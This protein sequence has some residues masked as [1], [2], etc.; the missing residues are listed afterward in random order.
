MRQYL[1]DALSRGIKIMAL[2]TAEKLMAIKLD[3]SLLLN[4]PAG[5]TVPK[6][7][8]SKVKA[9]IVHLGVGG[10]HRSHQALYMDELI[11][12]F[13]QTEWGIC[14]VGIMPG[15]K[16]MNRALTSQDFLYTL[17]EREGTRDTAKIIGSLK[18]HIFGVENPEA[19]FEAIASAETKI[20]SLTATEGGYCF[21]QA[22]GEFDTKHPGIINDL[23]NPMEPKTIF[24]YIAQGLSRRM[25]NGA[26]PVTILS[27]DNMQGN[28]KIAKKMVLA[29][30][31]LS[32]PT[33]AS[34]IEKN[35]TFPNTMVDRITPVTTE[36]ERELV[37]SFGIDDQFPVV[38]E[39][40]RQWVI[41]DNFAAGRP[42]LEK[43]G[44]Q[45]SA[46]VAPYEKMKIRLLNATHSAMGYLG[47]LCGHKFIHEI[48]QDKD[49][50]PYL[51]ERPQ[52]ICLLSGN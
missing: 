35:V 5:V 14:G 44:V 8:R 3:S 38:S 24:G 48:G 36:S 11:S 16:E 47:Y 21:N 52:T 12:E 40:F 13:G 39:S 17:V 32:N 45:F 29:F 46:D 23:E 2:N 25:N 50:I 20:V 9:G 10:F 15:D 22:T 6:Y 43:V 34:W 1:K 51:A 37:R 33:L 31:Q 7:D 4:P 18:T 42:P 19:V 28:G 41:E 26:G 49:F 27:C 30:C